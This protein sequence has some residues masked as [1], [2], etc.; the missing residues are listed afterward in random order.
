IKK[1]RLVHTNTHFTSN[2][3]FGKGVL[4]RT[5]TKDGKFGGFQ[6]IQSWDVF[7]NARYVISLIA[8]GTRHAKFV[9]V[10]EVL[11]KQARKSAKGFRYRTRELPG[12]E[13]LDGRLI[14]HWGDGT[15]SWAQW[16]HSEGNKDIVELL[17]PNYVM[18]FP[19]FY[20]VAISYEQLAK[21]VNN[22][23]SNREW[24]R[25]LASISG[26]Y[27]ILDQRTGK[28]Y[29]GSAYGKGGIWAR[30]SKYVRNPSG[31]NKLL[32]TL[33]RRHTGRQRHF[34]FSIMRVLEPGSTKEDVMGQEVITKQKLGTRAF[35]L[36]D[37]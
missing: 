30:W 4:E 3:S 2:A 18:A 22:P 1:G 5:L 28:Q 10:W 24:Q 8:E 36:N 31:G 6:N 12:F 33:L 26:V 27:L 29:V 23:G 14:V 9:G 32:E 19:G 15:R 25:M 11:S 34:L 35:G 13:S 20:N 21:M 16:L 17:P 7:G 37:N